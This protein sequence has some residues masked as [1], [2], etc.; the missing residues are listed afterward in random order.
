M[1]KKILSLTVVAALVLSV[2]STAMAKKPTGNTKPPHGSNQIKKE[3]YQ[4]DRAKVVGGGF[5]P[6]I[7]FNPSEKD[8]IYARTDMGGAYRWNPAD[9]TWKQLMSFVSFDE[10]NMLGVESLATD[11]VDTNRLYIASGTYSNDWTD[12]NGV[13]L[14][15]KDKG[16]TFERTELPFKLGG[17]MPGR[18]MGERLAVDPNDNRILYLGARSGN[19]LWKSIDYGKTWNKVTSFTAVGNVK[20]YYNDIVGPAWVTFDKST[21][22]K[23]HA[24]QTIYVGVADTDNSIYRSTDGGKSWEPLPGQPNQKFM[25][26][27]GVLGSNGILYITYNEFIGPYEGGKGSVWKYDTKTGV[28]TDISPTGNTDNPYGGLA[29]DRN[30]PDTLMVA[31]LN[32]WWPDDNIY[33]ST[34]GGKTWNS[35]WT[36]D[37]SKDPVRDNKFTIDYSLAPWL[38]WGEEKSLPEISPK[39]GWMIGDLEIDPFNSDRVMYGTGA[40]LYGTNNMTSLDHNEDVKISVQAEGIEETAILGLISPPSGASLISSM[41]DIGGFRHEDLSKAPQMITNPYLGNSTD[42]DYAELNPNIVVRVGN[43]EGKSARMG[44]SLDNGKT[45]TPVVNAWN[46]TDEDKTEGGWVA[47]GADGS[48]VVWSPKGITDTSPRLVSF[49]LDQGRSWTASKGIPEGAVVSS[50]RVNPRKFYGMANGQ[51][52]ISNDS[53]A[54]FV[55]SKA[56]GL[57]TLMTS[58]FKAVPGNEGDIWIASAKDNSDISSPFG[59]WHS[60]D[61]GVTFT[62]VNNVQEA[63]T[64]GFGKAAP[65]QKY[66]ALYSYAKIN[67]KYGVYRSDNKGVTWTRINDDDNQFG[68]ANRTITGDPRVYGRVYIG[69]NG[70]GIVIGDPEKSNKSKNKK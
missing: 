27:H 49:S 8:L 29:V 61:G 18:S 70:L 30:N 19:G 36:L 56:G 5:I 3:K 64:I 11:P 15:S 44:I 66:M 39:L 54:S 62:K 17:N 4:W 13:I 37:Y 24:T 9:K 34:D 25:P 48:S 41:G 16:N 50:D 10:W 58:K 38:D 35:L 59:L 63:A 2:G 28:W 53:G 33:R 51:F 40:T 32:K 43:A 69:T 42:L 1:F 7:V 31:T 22:K 47:V 52:Y 55:I 14:R 45:W 46:A 67:N 60:T 57:P 20:D 12:M 26:H 65:G 23:G 21:G 6:G 68:A